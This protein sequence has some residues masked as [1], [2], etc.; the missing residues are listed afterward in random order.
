MVMVKVKKMDDEAGC[1]I[2][3]RGIFFFISVL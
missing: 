2:G 1:T 3:N